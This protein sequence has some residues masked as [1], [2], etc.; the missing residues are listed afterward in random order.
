MFISCEEFRYFLLIWLKYC[1]NII[2]GWIDWINGKKNYMDIP[3]VSDFFLIDVLQVY[4]P[5]IPAIARIVMDMQCIYLA[6]LP[7]CLM[8]AASP[9][10]FSFSDPAT[11]IMEGIINFHNDLMFFIVA[12]SIFVLWMLIRC[13]MLFSSKGGDRNLGWN[14]QLGSLGSLGKNSNIKIENKNINEESKLL[15][16]TTQLYS[17]G[18]NHHTPIEIAWTVTPAL[19][20]MLIAVPSFALLYSIEEFV[21]PSIT[22]K[23]TGHQWYWHYEYSN[24]KHAALGKYINS[25]KFESYMIPNEDLLDGDLRLLEVDGRI[26][27]PAGVHIQVSVT[28]AD[29]LHC[30]AVPSLGVK[31]DAC[32]GRLNQ[33]SIFIKRPGVFYG[34]CSEIC[35]VNHGFMP[36]VVSSLYPK[37]YLQLR[38]EQYIISLLRNSDGDSAE[39]KH[40]ELD[41]MPCGGVLLDTAGSEETVS[42]ATPGETAVLPKDNDKLDA[43]DE[44]VHPDE[45]RYLIIG[46]KVL[47][48]TKTGERVMYDGHTGE[49]IMYN[50]MTCELVPYVP[51]KNRNEVLFLCLK[52]NK[53]EEIKNI[54]SEYRSNATPPK[55]KDK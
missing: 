6:Y 44:S 21:E 35:G 41:G 40:L 37:D 13:I 23:C 14:N 29:V 1:L 43:P 51:N 52:S 27:V 4:E 9:W 17:A 49:R 30:W 54:S 10:Q 33:T 2:A 8:D 47:F 12:I 20:L 55:P 26:M 38:W 7:I 39:L 36:I 22:V 25:L 34:Q 3:S 18:F 16:D 24:C 5:L 46:D 32:P 42:V 19:I 48:D 15:L 45:G 50:P 53:D 11:P 28:A 31:V